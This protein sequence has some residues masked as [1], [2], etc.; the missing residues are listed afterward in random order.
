MLT[1][2]DADDGANDE[3]DIDMDA[4]DDGGEADA[5]TRLIAGVLV[6]LAAAAALAAADA[7]TVK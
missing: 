2:D 5:V 1:F 7:S 4:T 6:S 3:F